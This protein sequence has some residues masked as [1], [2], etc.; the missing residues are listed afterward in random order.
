[1]LQMRAISL[2]YMHGMLLGSISLFWMPLGDNRHQEKNAS[3]YLCMRQKKKKGVTS[4]TPE[5]AFGEE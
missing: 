1:M 4:A 3:T 2:V 5:R